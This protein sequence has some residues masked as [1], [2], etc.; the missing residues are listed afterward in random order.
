MRSAAL[1]TG[2]FAS[3]GGVLGGCS[4]APQPILVSAEEFL[5]RYDAERRP[6]A[7]HRYLGATGGRHRL[8]YYEITTGKVPELLALYVVPRTA[9]P[10]DFP[11]H[12]QPKI[13]FPPI[14]RPRP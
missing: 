3:L 1:I 12:D 14:D 6:H 7:Y 11:M 4:A 9:L 5:A 13:T 10:K 2:L 8:G